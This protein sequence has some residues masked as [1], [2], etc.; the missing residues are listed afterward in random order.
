MDEISN[1]YLVRKFERGVLLQC[2]EVIEERNY[3]GGIFDITGL[4]FLHILS[5][6]TSENYVLFAPILI[7]DNWLAKSTVGFSLDDESIRFVLFWNRD[8]RIILRP[9]FITYLKLIVSI[10]HGQ[11]KW[12]RSVG[13]PTNKDGLLPTIRG[14]VFHTTIELQSKWIQ[15]IDSYL[16]NIY[17][18]LDKRSALKY[19]DI[20]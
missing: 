8:S 2:S 17:W 14:E 9:K 6:M 15:H 5:I 19:R 10:Y 3:S 16:R 18:I 12:Q 13:I 7:I 11:C 20:S 1:N 4:I